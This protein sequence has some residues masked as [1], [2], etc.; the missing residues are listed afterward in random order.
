MRAEQHEV[1]IRHAVPIEIALDIGLGRG[2][3][4]LDAQLALVAGESARPNEREG[5]I[6][7]RPGGCIDRGESSLSPAAKSATT[8]CAEAATPPMSVTELKTNVSLPA[9]PMR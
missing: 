7:R 8:S 1:E 2:R 6:C 5:I 4:D 3:V 9:P